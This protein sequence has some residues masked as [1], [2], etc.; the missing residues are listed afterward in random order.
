MALKASRFLNPKADIVFKR[1]FGEHKNLLIS[2]LNALMPLPKGTL[3]QDLEYLTPEQVPIIPDFRR[4][5]VDVKC[6]DQLN[7][8]FIVEMQMEWVA[9]FASR[10]L[11]GASQVYV[12]QLKRGEPY[13]EL[14]PVYGLGL[15]NEIFEPLSTQWF[16]HY[17]M[18][19]VKDTAK[20]ID[21]I[22]LVLL[23]LPKFKPNTRAETKLGALWL[24]FLNEAEKLYEIPEDFKSYPE[25]ISAF[26][27]S[28]ESAYS[29]DQLDYYN[30]CWDAVST[31]KTLVIDSFIKGKEEGREEG[32]KL[33][34]QKQARATAKV[35][36][37]EGLSLEII[38]KSTGL[39]LKEIENL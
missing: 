34:A 16:H 37:A 2:F 11:Y 27:L 35:M 7:R 21:G 25:L 24:R 17:K 22:E 12:H 38:A 9:S 29:R 14:C 23:E 28:Q 10:L 15:I 39:D 13:R 18:S 6:F 26:E 8:T 1:I 30:S 3:I 19:N 32:E 5:I 4:T 36:K 31:E 20:S 33:G